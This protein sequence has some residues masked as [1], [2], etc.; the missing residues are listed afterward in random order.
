MHDVAVIG[1]GIIGLAVARDLIRQDPTLRVI[2]LE[3][4]EVVAAHQT[5]RNSGVVHSGIYYTPGSLKARL[6]T[7][8]G[9][10]L[11]DLCIQVGIPFIRCGKVLVASA[12]AEIPALQE[13]HRRGTLNGLEGLEQIGPAELRDLEPHVTGVAALRVPGAAIVDFTAVAHALSSD[14]EGKG[15]EVM[16]DTEVADARSDKEGTSLETTRGRVAAAVV[17]NCAGLHA[18][19][20]AAMLGAAPDVRIVPFR[21]EYKRL[22]PSAR[23]LVNGLVYPIPD[24][25]LPFLGAHFTP[26]VHGEVTVG[27]NAVLALAREGY[28][29]RT[30]DV[31][32]LRQMVAWKGFRAMAHNHWRSGLGEYVRSLSERSF[33]RALQRLVPQLRGEDLLPAPAGVRA[34][35]VAQDGKLIDDFRVLQTE[36]AVHVVNAPSPAATASLAIGRLV[37]G[38]VRE[39]ATRLGR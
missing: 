6:C 25:T 20:L 18:D 26:T 24:P 37:A 14:L 9:A 12:P 11:L 23:G 1:A 27:P 3:K 10:E 15:V 21:G 16:L 17:V 5:G 34:Q 29:R 38:L 36:R 19:K 2:V 33:L 32:E 31:S 4:E 35:A 8:G 22:A 30:V 39:T 28:T 7:R 13:L